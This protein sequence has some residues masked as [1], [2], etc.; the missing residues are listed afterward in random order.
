MV[1]SGQH[2]DVIVVRANGDMERIDTI[3][4]GLPIGLEADIAPFVN[5]VRIPFEKDDLILLHTDGVTEAENSSGELFGIERL[6]NEALRL[7]ERSANAIV[8]GIVTALMEYVG[9]QKIRDDITLL[10]L[11]HR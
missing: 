8:S 4:L 1:L 2:E 3:D 7:K 6:C 11:R 9:T 5:S 10:V